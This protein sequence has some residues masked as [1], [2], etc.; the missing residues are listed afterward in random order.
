MP[1]TRLAKTRP[2]LPDGY[3]FGWGRFRYALLG[4]PSIPEPW[5]VPLREPDPLPSY[6]HFDDALGW[7]RTPQEV[8]LKGLAKALS[9]HGRLYGLTIETPRM[10]PS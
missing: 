9:S 7:I 5:A 1:E 10:D 6:V 4:H 2:T 8:A 3:Q